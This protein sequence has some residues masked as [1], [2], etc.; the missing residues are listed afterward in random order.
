MLT[1]SLHPQ[2]LSRVQQLNIA[3]FL[4]KPL[5]REKVN[6]ILQNHFDRHL[7]GYRNG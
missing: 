5:T 2:D 6:Q 7:P 4:N 3:G 1:T